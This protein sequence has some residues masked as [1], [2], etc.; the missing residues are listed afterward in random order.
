MFAAIFLIHHI[1]LQ[2]AESK[3]NYC[4]HTSTQ[5]LPLIRCISE[6]S[7][8]QLSSNVRSGMQSTN[9]IKKAIAKKLKT[10]IGAIVEQ[11]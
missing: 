4:F 10:L 8:S 1:P 7:V 11:N 3:K 6:G 5:N 2:I 9:A